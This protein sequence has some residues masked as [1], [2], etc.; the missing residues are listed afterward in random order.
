M[1]FL[2]PDADA[3]DE[4]A[5]FDQIPTTSSVALASVLT[6]T[7]SV[8][9]TSLVTASGLTIAIPGAGTYTVDYDFSWSG[10]SGNPDY[11]FSFSG[12]ATDNGVQHVKRQSSGGG[13]LQ[14]YDI[15]MLGT[16]VGAAA[17]ADV[18]VDGHGYFTCSNAGNLSVAFLRASGTTVLRKGC[19]VKVIKV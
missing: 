19:S 12:T 16:N 7:V 14:T 18:A 5:T 11:R 6:S 1:R 8:T 2:G 17:T 15:P 3:A 13:L 10:G 4:V 9:T